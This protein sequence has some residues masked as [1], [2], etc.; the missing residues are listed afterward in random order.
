ME[1]KKFLIIGL[2]SMGK[3]RT[4]CLQSLDRTYSIYGHD[5]NADRQA[6]S[7]NQYGI[8]IIND[9]L[10]S[11][12]RE[13]S[14]VV[15]ICVPP[16]HHHFYMKMCLENNCNFFVEASVL[17]TGYEELIGQTNKIVVS[18]SA[19]LLFHPAIK[20]IKEIV[21]SNE[22]GKVSNFVYHSG[23]YLPDWHNYENV[24]DF[25]VSQK[26]TGGC[27]EI[28]PF[29]LTWMVQIFG[30]PRSV[31]AQF[32]KTMDIQG[33]ENIDDTYSAI[34]N[35]ESFFGSLTVDVVSRIATRR[36]NLNFENGMIIWDWNNDHLIVKKGNKEIEKRH[37]AKGKSD[38]GYNQNIS[39]QM[40]IDEIQSF[41]LKVDKVSD[42]YPNTLE[43]DWKV[44]KIL[45]KIEESNINKTS[46]TV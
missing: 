35:W 40:Y 4:R 26:E 27:R 37:Y 39:E 42:E 2:G 6:Q 15:L 43:Q 22:L 34:L 24:S 20:M 44:L 32:G 29:E 38:S 19:T 17:D 30:Q 10:Q 5:L 36:L 9:D 16:D 21:S 7:S 13:Y 12:M 14:P 28:I 41:L 25:Y 33:A 23:Q 45:Y 18:P 3:R 31:M 8:R 46:I 1:N 11:F